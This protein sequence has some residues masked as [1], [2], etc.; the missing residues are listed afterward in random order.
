ME[1]APIAEFVAMLASGGFAGAAVYITAVEHPARVQCGTAV[2]VKQFAPS[3]RRAAKMQGGLAVVGLVAGI[4]ATLQG[5]GI[6]WAIGGTVL[7]AVVPLTLIGIMP[8][9]KRLL[10]RSLD[11]E[12]AEARDLLERWGRLHAV[13]TVLGSLAFATFTCLLLWRG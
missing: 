6:G 5:A 12:S 1:P 10:D 9:N 4:V 8:T 2:A 7:G 3:Y 13:R 11:V